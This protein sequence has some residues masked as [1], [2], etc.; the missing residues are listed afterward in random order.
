MSRVRFEGSTSAILDPSAAEVSAAVMVV[1]RDMASAT[2][3]TVQRPALHFMGGID[4]SRSPFAAPVKDDSIVSFPGKLLLERH[5]VSLPAST[6][7]VLTSPSTVLTP[8]AREIL[9]KRGVTVR[10]S[11]ASGLGSPSPL[12]AGEWAVLRL[13]ES[14]Q[15]QSLE[16]MLIG[17]GGEGWIGFGASAE[18]AVGWLETQPSGHLAVLAQSAAN[19]LWWLI[20]HGVRAAQTNA[21]AEVERIVT[22]FAP[23]CLVVEP[24]RLAIHDSRQIFRTWRSLGFRPAN[25][26]DDGLANVTKEARS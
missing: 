6:R 5:A 18:A 21:S 13:C 7:Q 24:A 23:R 15:A 26:V 22:E 11:N 8:L 17:R 10:V 16:A 3:L 20:R 4:H 12:I 25:L 19:S 14:P 1:L 2:A 9:R